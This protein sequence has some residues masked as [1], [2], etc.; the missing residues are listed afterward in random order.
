[1][2]KD[3][4]NATAFREGSRKS[5]SILNLSFDESIYLHQPLKWLDDRVLI[6]CEM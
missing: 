5:P 4:R 2:E 6:I 3:A 1:V